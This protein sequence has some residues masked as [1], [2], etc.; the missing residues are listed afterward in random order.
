MPVGRWRRCSSDFLLGGSIVIE[1]I[2]ALDGLGY[3]A[4]QSITHKDFPWT[5]AV[6]MLLAVAYVADDAG[7]RPAERLDRPAPEGGGLTA[8]ELS[9]ADGRREGWAKLGRRVRGHKGLVAGLLI[10]VLI[11]LAAL[12]APLLSP[13]DPYAQDLTK[14]LV[15]RSGTRA[16]NGSILWAPTTSGATTFPEC[17]MARGSR[18]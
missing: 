13:H 8:V 7:G 4:Y 11:V 5:Q 17:C 15:P 16:G 10:F 9:A 1:T 3:L 18:C 12:L 6:L 2:F 14:R